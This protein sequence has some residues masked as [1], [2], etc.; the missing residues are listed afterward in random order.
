LMARA[1]ARR[2]ARLFRGVNRP[3]LPPSGRLVGI[4][5]FRV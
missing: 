3:I 1:S 5:D 2:V 4:S